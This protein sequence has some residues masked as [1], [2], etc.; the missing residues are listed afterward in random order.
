MKAKKILPVLLAAA[1]GM[2]VLGGCGNTIDGNK[3]GATLNGEEVSLGFMNFMA[4]YQQAVYDGQLGA[5]F[6]T[7]MWGQDLFGEGTDRKSVV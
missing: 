1:L 7:T 4:R 6:G 5:M 2:S 3:T